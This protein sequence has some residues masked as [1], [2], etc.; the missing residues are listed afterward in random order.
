MKRWG[1]LRRN[2]H[3][4]DDGEGAE[5]QV[6]QQQRQTRSAAV[7]AEIVPGAP[8]QGNV[9]TAHAWQAAQVSQ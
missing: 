6:P 1:Q 8:V 9:R 2:A 3:Q 4:E 5:A 7:P